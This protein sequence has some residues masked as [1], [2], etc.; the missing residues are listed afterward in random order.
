MPKVFSI[1]FG[2][3]VTVAAAWCFGQV[4]LARLQLRLA[5]GE[6]P[7][8]AL[9]LG[10]AVL[11]LALFTMA[12]MRIVYDASLLALALFAGFAAW[13]WGRGQAREEPLDPLPR[14]WRVLFLTVWLPFAAIAL[15][16]AMAPEM[17][18]DGS[19]YHLG[20]ISRFYRAH[21]FVPMPHL[22]YGQMPQGFDILFL[23]AFAFG[24]HSAAALVHCSFLLALP[25][26]ALRIGQ[27]AG[28]AAA[29]AVAGLLVMASPVVMIDGAS[30]YN[31][32]ALAFVLLAAFGLT[33]RS[34][35]A[36][37][38]LGLL[39]GYAFTIK[40]TAA[41]AFPWALALL[42]A[43]GARKWRQLAVY[44]AA[45]AVMITPWLLRNSLTY[46]NP[47][48]PF[49]TRWFPN[50]F[51]HESFEQDYREWMRWYDGLERGSQLP[52][53][54]IVDGSFVGGLL[55]PVF[56]LAPL[57][58]LALRHPLGRRALLAAAVLGLPYAANVGTRFLIPAL[59]FLALAM[60]LA[61]PVRALPVLLI[62]HAVLS[63]PP[64]VDRYCGT[65]AWRISQLYPQ[66]AFRLEDP[67]AFMAREWPPARLADLIEQATPAGS[68]I[69]A[70]EPP[71]DAYTSREVR[72]AHL[73]AEGDRL[74][75]LL[76]MPLIRERQPLHRFQFDFEECELSAVRIMQTAG[77]GNDVWSVA[78]V[79][80]LGPSGPLPRS[81]GWRLRASA[82]PWD[83]PFAFDNSPVTR[84]RAWQRLRP[85]TW[86]E[87]DF[88]LTRPVRAVALD[89]S[90]GQWA[91]RLRLEGRDARG[92]WVALGGEP[93]RSERPPPLELRRMATDE[94]KRSGIT[95][96]LVT[97]NSYRWEDFQD[98]D[99]LWG[100]REAGRV[101]NARLYRLE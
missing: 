56:L 92:R 101:D 79:H 39:T 80:V 89:M 87:V 74:A 82:F 26:L 24:R 4:L 55:G 64:V 49:F 54:L 36:A 88:G 41:V 63:L 77:G 34:A 84:W 1:L 14:G 83:I 11:S 53:A 15:L 22:M 35:D 60:A 32:V 97:G 16:H 91:V 17:S 86:I 13:R 59:P 2:A 72:S 8:Y 12:A 6:R 45:A 62:A 21:G 47:V 3:G 90:A 9:A 58:L 29:G 94:L 66:V 71:P 23:M 19:S 61:W 93:S 65:H 28:H 50:P 76:L 85:G 25:W 33:L 68:V 96:V 67:R 75:D 57:G 81:P 98:N 46:G 51:M 78:E 95:H 69:F 5:R 27:R 52:W 99:D 7:L 20:V 38:P 37:L 42:L 44:S 100:I 30:A 43:R 10:S 18:P 31:D 48:A 73:S 40:Y 70:F